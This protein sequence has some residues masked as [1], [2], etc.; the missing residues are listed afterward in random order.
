MPGNFMVTFK[1]RPG[2]TAAMTFTKE[3]IDSW[4]EEGRAGELLATPLEGT[5][6][7]WMRTVRIIGL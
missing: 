3:S 7:C 5:Q 4:S 2:E 6:D 1:P